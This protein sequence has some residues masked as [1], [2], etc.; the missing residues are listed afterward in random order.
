ME[1]L[2]TVYFAIACIGFFC[3][4]LGMDSKWVVTGIL[5]A[6]FIV[7][8]GYAFDAWMDKAYPDPCQCECV[9]TESADDP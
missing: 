1:I 6:A 4:I 2:Y 8:A 7:S 9:E 5:G 3:Y